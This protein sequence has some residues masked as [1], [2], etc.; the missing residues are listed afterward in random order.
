MPQSAQPRQ[1]AGPYACKQASLVMSSE[2]ALLSTQPRRRPHAS[3]VCMRREEEEEEVEAEPRG[4]AFACPRCYPPKHLRLHNTVSQ[5]DGSIFQ[6]QGKSKATKRPLRASHLQHQHHR[7]LEKTR[8][9]APAALRV[10]SMPAI[11][12][13]QPYCAVLMMMMM[14]DTINTP[15]QAITSALTLSTHAHSLHPHAVLLAPLTIPPTMPRTH[16]AIPT[17]TTSPN[18]P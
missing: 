3:L 18:C 10:S 7:N 5:V 6:Q 15:A 16:T 1:G 13:R 11:S 12:I 4:L 9:G 2:R 17:N 14:F 8:N